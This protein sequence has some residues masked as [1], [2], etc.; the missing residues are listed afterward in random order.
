[1]A[2]GRYSIGIDLGT[3]NCALCYVDSLATDKTPR[4]LQIP[5][6]HSLHSISE[7][8]LL[9]SFLELHDRAPTDKN[10]RQV[11]LPCFAEP[12]SIAGHLAREKSI[13][14]PE[15]TVSSAKSW[16]ASSH[17]NSRSRIL[18]WGSAL[19]ELKISPLEA[20]ARYLSHLK[21]CWDNALAGANPAYK[22]ENSEVTVTVPAS[23]DESAIALTLEA[24]AIA[25]Y[26][27][28]IRILEEPQ[29]AFYHWLERHELC[30]L[31]ENLPA[32]RVISV[33]VVDVGGGTT[34][35]SLFHYQ[36]GSNSVKR[37]SVSEHILLGG[38]N[39]DLAI[40]HL[41]ESAAGFSPDARQW[42]I[43][44]NQ[45]RRIKEEI[46][47]SELPLTEKAEISITLP[48]SGSDLFAEAENLTLDRGKIT[49]LILDGFFPAC[50]PTAKATKISTALRDLGLNYA[51]DTAITRHIAEFIAGAEINALLFT[52]GA[53]SPEPLQK[54][55]IEIIA[56]WQTH[57]PQV[58]KNDSCH[59]AVAR[60]AAFFC[61]QVSHGR[62]LISGGLPHALYL[63]IH[64]G[65]RGDI[66]QLLCL[67]PYGSE[68]GFTSRLSK[69]DLSLRV[70]EAVRFSCYSSSNRHKDKPGEF[71]NP[72][73]FNFHKLPEMKTTLVS[74]NLTNRGATVSVYLECE[75]DELGRLR[76]YCVSR[77]NP[78]QRWQLTFDLEQNSNDSPTTSVDRFRKFDRTILPQ[79]TEALL[80]VFG[81]KTRNDARYN[82]KTLQ[83]GLESLLDLPRDEWPTELL[84]NIWDTLAPAMGRKGRSLPHEL[85]WLTLAGLALRP[86]FGAEGDI[87]RINEAWKLYQ[88]GIS[89]PKETRATVQWWI[90]WR[91]VA[92]GLSPEQQQIMFRDAEKSLSGASNIS[93]E[94]LLTLCSLEKLPPTE[95]LALLKHAQRFFSKN[96]IA[97]SAYYSALARLLTRVPFQA[98][99]STVLPA[100]DIEDTISDMLGTTPP[101][102]ATSAYCSALAR[103]SRLTGERTLDLPH[104]MRQQVIEKL[105]A[106]GFPAEHTRTISEIVAVQ[107]KD[108]QDYFGESLPAG[109]ILGTKR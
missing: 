29:A 42:S 19:H 68:P 67:A 50:E 34:D 108:R 56:S 107:D 70:N 2:V 92:G 9:P 96:Q 81:K 106:L 79:V 73:V 55:L 4:I 23:F 16:L 3:S 71:I 39:M 53:L 54:R 103:I 31:G 38:D 69:H 43:L 30:S 12:E 109:L 62:R 63:A 72:D 48:G 80:D 102:P 6:Y 44:V 91:R 83:K 27:P 76:I 52:G 40:A 45:C 99:S 13:E 5:Q 60:G 58:L 32:E 24:A 57:T 47:S 82:A 8:E 22:L 49:K 90:F 25:G 46:F 11:S 20:T 37:I 33:L 64:S 1:M 78:G 97:A 84:R 10:D 14:A 75:I 93:P 89:H 21:Y 77:D 85:C 26:P 105:L 94:Q 36:P 18:P 59:L 87:I 65:R 100:T 86:G 35:L 95:K 17:I 104:S 41:F 74:E 51:A 101:A 98:D 88:V 66:E 15:R 7:N 28:R 61:H